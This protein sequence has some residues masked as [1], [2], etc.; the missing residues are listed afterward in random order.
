MCLRVLFE[1]QDVLGF[2]VAV[3]TKECL[4]LGEGVSRLVDIQP[5]I[6][7]VSQCRGD[8]LTF[9]DDPYGQ[10]FTKKIWIGV[11][12]PYISQAAPTRPWEKEMLCPVGL[13]R[14]DELDKVG[15]LDLVQ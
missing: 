1:Y 15:I 13:K 8:S 4:L 5:G 10:I 14:G 6:M 7:N 2:E 12:L 9:L 11:P 3:S